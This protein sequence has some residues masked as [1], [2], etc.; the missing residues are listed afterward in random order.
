MAGPPPPAPTAN[1]GWISLGYGGMPKALSLFATPTSSLSPGPVQASGPC[2]PP[3]SWVPLTGPAL[4]P[5]CSRVKSTAGGTSLHSCPVVRLAHPD[6][7]GQPRNARHVAQATGP[8]PCQVP[9]EP[10]K[11]LGSQE[12]CQHL[13]VRPAV[14]EGQM[15]QPLRENHVC[16]SGSLGAAGLGVSRLEGPQ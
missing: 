5:C 7:Q 4:G 11:K 6:V 3:P 9:Q 10:G 16:V 14:H 2:L 8:A 15:M 12:G 13:G 1:F